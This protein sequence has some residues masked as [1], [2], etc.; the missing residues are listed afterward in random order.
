[1]RASIKLRS[2]PKL[3]IKQG[4]NARDFAL[5]KESISIGRTPEN[6]IELKDSLISRRHTSIVRK[7]ER[8]VVYDLG[9]S[10]GTFLNRE[11]IDNRPLENGDVIRVGD[12]EITFWAEDGPP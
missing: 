2:L 3:H 1:M 8:W 12:T 9:S 7:G 5:I 11:R 4:A 6:D 10:N